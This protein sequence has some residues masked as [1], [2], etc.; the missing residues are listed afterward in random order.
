MQFPVPQ[1]TDVEDKIIGGLTIRQFG[2][3]FLSGM[4]VVLAYTSTKNLFITGIIFLL[5]AVPGIIL[6]FGPFNGRKMYTC[7][8]F[9]LKFVFASKLYV[10]HKQ[11]RDGVTEAEVATVAVSKKADPV[12]A[13]DATTRLRSLN[14]LLEQKAREEAELLKKRK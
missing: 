3:L 11:G 5:F 1:F 12:S 7:I 10:Y 6:A 14:Y 9:I 4:M 13:E 8:P 2:I